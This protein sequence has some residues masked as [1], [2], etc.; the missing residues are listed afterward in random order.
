M[1]LHLCTERR[2][3]SCVDP[4]ADSL[5]TP[6]QL[7]LNQPFFHVA[8]MRARTCPAA[9]QMLRCHYA[10]HVGC[11]ERPHRCP[12]G[13][14]ISA[15]TRA[16]KYERTCRARTASHHRASPSQQHQ[17]A[18][19]FTHYLNNQRK[20]VNHPSTRAEKQSPKP[21]PCNSLSL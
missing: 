10:Q 19:A 21:L 1:D 20:K 13:K 17:P 18:K 16:Y 11:E 8:T 7:V 4:Y 12:L 3:S 6:S 9:T 15:L 5:G 14:S 2:S